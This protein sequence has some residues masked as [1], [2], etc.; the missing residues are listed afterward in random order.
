M[1]YKVGDLVAHNHEDID[2]L[3][4][5]SD[6]TETHVKVYFFKWK[7]VKNNPYK[8]WATED[9]LRKNPLMPYTVDVLSNDKD[10]PNG[11]KLRIIQKVKK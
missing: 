9:D 4:W 11:S 1:M 10:C 2:S 3:G 8:Y 6:V 7:I 5:I